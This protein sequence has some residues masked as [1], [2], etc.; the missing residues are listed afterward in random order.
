[1]NRNVTLTYQDLITLH[2]SEDDDPKHSSD[3]VVS[4]VAFRSGIIASKGVLIPDSE[5]V[6]VTKSL[7]GAPFL[8]GHSHD[9]RDVIGKVSEAW[10]ENEIVRFRG[11]IK[12][13]DIA[14]KV[15]Q[16]LLNS[17]SVGLHVD[18]FEDIEIDGQELKRLNGITVKELSIVIFP[19][20]EGATFE[21]SFEFSFEELDDQP[22]E[23]EHTE[24]DFTLMERALVNQGKIVMDRADFESIQNELGDKRAMNDY[25]SKQLWMLSNCDE[26]F[27]ENTLDKVDSLTL[28]QIQFLWGVYQDMSR[29]IGPQG[30]V[31]DD[32][33]IS[34]FEIAKE[35]VREV[36]FHT[37][38]D[39]KLKG[40]R[41]IKDIII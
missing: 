31:I 15:R 27:N 13:K 35:D 41:S 9:P 7:K 1:M 21:P 24:V 20:V 11:A 36:I 6:S 40:L 5:L 33:R 18:S 23:T 37:R 19:A 26:T 8:V 17:V 22:V 12:D 25:L 16:G 10:R 30:V 39:G 14:E 2:K 32:S 29:N 38:R 28:D 4:G 34:S 3:V